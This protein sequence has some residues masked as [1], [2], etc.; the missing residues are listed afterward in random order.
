[1]LDFT[2]DVMKL[3]DDQSRVYSEF[4]FEKYRKIKKKAINT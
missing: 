1:M 3:A 2:P 4:P